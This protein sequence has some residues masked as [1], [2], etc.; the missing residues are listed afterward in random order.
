MLRATRS[1]YSPSPGHTQFTKIHCLSAT[2]RSP[3]YDLEQIY[4]WNYEHAPELLG[5][6]VP[7][8]PGL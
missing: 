1:D 6:P 8:R 3:R 4:T 5:V 7:A 2:H